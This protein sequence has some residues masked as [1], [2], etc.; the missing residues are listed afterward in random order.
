MRTFIFNLR[1]T[2]FYVLPFTDFVLRFISQNIKTADLILEFLQMQVFPTLQK[3]SYQADSTKEHGI[4]DNGTIN[5]L[6][7]SH[8]M[9]K[10]AAL[11]F[12]CEEAR[13]PNFQTEPKIF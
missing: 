10:N 7:L 12:K 3:Q 9:E 11:T 6:K 5:E 4:T 13:K 1:V 2:F 8:I